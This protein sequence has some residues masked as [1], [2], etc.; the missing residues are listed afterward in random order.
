MTPVLGRKIEDERERSILLAYMYCIDRNA[1]RFIVED[2]N[3][4][5]EMVAALDLLLTDVWAPQTYKVRRI[6]RS[7]VFFQFASR[8]PPQLQE[9]VG[10][11]ISN[12]RHGVVHVDAIRNLRDTGSKRI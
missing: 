5:D 8:Q 7:G 11:W 4:A 3:G 9:I 2:V 6:V 10:E 12:R 1:P